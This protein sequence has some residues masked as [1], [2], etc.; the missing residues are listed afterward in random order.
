[1][2]IALPLNCFQKLDK[3][4]FEFDGQRSWTMNACCREGYEAHL[5]KELSNV[6]PEDIH[7]VLEEYIMASDNPMRVVQGLVWRK[8]ETA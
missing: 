2:C 5:S 6:K 4:A 1:M 7:Y 3:R 8:R